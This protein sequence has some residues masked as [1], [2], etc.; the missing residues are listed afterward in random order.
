MYT[1]L[2]NVVQG[3]PVAILNGEP[4]AGKPCWGFVESS[5]VA[6]RRGLPQVGSPAII[7]FSQVFRRFGPSTGVM[8]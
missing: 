5:E 7:H 8:V 2:N 1:D 6:H 3:L 4:K